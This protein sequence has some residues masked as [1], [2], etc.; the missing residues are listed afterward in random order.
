[1]PVDE[2]IEKAK[3]GR[4]QVITEDKLALLG[5]AIRIGATREQAC[6]YAGI[7]PASFYRFQKKYSWVKEWIQGLEMELPL[8]AKM[9]V[10][11]AIE[12]GNLRTAILYLET[13]RPEEFGKKKTVIHMG[14]CMKC[15]GTWEFLEEVF[16]KG[17][18]E[19]RRRLDT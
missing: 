15:N 14:L 19:S 11:K 5:Q 3:R 9:T 13:H 17:R 12:N 10:A 16:R 18:L 8:R 4:P 6:R 1:M 7:H 2:L